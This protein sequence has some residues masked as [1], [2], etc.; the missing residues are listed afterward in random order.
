MFASCRNITE[1]I[2]YLRGNQ[3]EYYNVLSK[4]HG[5]GIILYTVTTPDPWTGEEVSV[6]DSIRYDIT[7]G[8]LLS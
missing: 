6:S 4:K 7:T 8:D 2:T 1:V 5:V 3:V